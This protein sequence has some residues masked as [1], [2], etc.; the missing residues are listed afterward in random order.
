MMNDSSIEQMDVTESAKNIFLEAE[1]V[2]EN[3]DVSKESISSKLLAAELCANCHTIFQAMEWIER[4][5][6]KENEVEKNYVVDEY[7]KCDTSPPEVNYGQQVDVEE[8]SKDE[9]SSINMLSYMV[10]W[11]NVFKN[12]KA[13]QY[14]NSDQR[15]FG[16]QFNCN[17]DLD[18]GPNNVNIQTTN[19]D[20]EVEVEPYLERIFR[21]FILQSRKFVPKEN[22][23]ILNVDRFN[24]PQT[25]E[26]ENKSKK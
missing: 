23:N 4:N 17:I 11:E 26:M 22:I 1:R 24:F 25:G 16:T 13:V 12:S 3:A 18:G 7:S 19:N 9:N 20:I 21:G 2:S 15:V 6:K 10:T 14:G 8:E 5:S